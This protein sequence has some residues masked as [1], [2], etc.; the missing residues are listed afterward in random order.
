MDNPA[1]TVR[2]VAN[3]VNFSTVA[4]LVV[5]RVGRAKLSHGPKGLW[6]A[7]RYAL[8]FPV[9]GAFTVGNVII[10]PRTIAEIGESTVTHEERHTWQYMMCGNLF[11]PLY[12]TAMGWSWIRTGDRAA[13]N[14]FERAAGL[15]DGGYADVPVRPLRSLF[16]RRVSG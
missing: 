15:T 16:E 7:E 1:V 3:M 12:L 2:A 5:A 6:Y 8:P 13:R 9:A 14:I 11:M 4:G 10:T